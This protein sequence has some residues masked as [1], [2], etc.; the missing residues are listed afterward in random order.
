MKLF[1]HLLLYNKTVIDWDSGNNGVV[2]PSDRHVALGLQA[3]MY[4][5]YLLFNDAILHMQTK[6]VNFWIKALTCLYK[7]TEQNYCQTMQKQ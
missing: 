4:C 5:G 2:G 1:S 7:K 3:D 6:N